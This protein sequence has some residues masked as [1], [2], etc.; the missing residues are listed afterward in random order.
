MTDIFALATTFWKKNRSGDGL[1]IGRPGLVIYGVAAF[2][3]STGVAVVEW[4]P[5]QIVKTRKHR[6]QGG[7]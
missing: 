5:W 3:K 1:T 7:K 4:N 6:I 2:A